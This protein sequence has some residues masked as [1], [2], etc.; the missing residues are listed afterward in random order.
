MISPTMSK[1]IG[2]LP[3]GLVRF[4]SNK[5]LNGYINKYAH[6]KVEN[7]EKLNDIKKPVIFICNHLSNSDALVLDRVLKD[8]DVTFVA[9]VKLS[10][11]PLTSLGLSIVKTTPVHPNSADKE[12][13]KKIIQ[14]IKSGNNVLIF[15]EG[16]R[17]RTGKMI[18]GKKGIILISKI[19]N[20]PI[21]PIGMTG[22]E[23]LLPINMEGKMEMERFQHSDIIVKIGEQFY[24]PEKLEKESK[25]DYEE[26][27]LDFIM[28]NIAKLL[29]EEYRG[30]YQ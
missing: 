22:T 21:V 16:T 19:C 20:V 24:L 5:L 4:I 13:I 7:K 15:P 8:H 6:I 11:N 30:E 2:H 17:S 3:K 14:I 23:K 1:I 12:G 26:R 18:K 28:R 27:A 10:S 25:K 9:G 29:P